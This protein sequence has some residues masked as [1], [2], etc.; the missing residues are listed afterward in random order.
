MFT[1]VCDILFGIC[2]LCTEWMHKKCSGKNESLLWEPIMQCQVFPFVSKRSDAEWGDGGMSRQ[3]LLSWDMLCG[4]GHAW[5]P[6]GSA[7]IVVVGAST[8]Y[9]KTLRLVYPGIFFSYH[10]LKKLKIYIFNYRY[11]F[12]CIYLSI[13]IFIWY[14]IPE[15]IFFQKCPFYWY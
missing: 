13:L 3:L 4:D 10:L 11:T 14:C 1:V 9:Q 6:F 15:N 8:A 2:I 12:S 7:F 5:L